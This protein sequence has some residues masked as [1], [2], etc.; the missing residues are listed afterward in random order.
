MSDKLRILFASYHS[1]LD[2]SSGSTISL[3][4]LFQLLIAGG[5]DCQAFCGA[6][7]DYEEARTIPQ[8]LDKVGAP[9]ETRKGGAYGLDFV[10]YNTIV[11]G[12]PIAVYETPAEPPA[13]KLSEKQGKVHLALFEKVLEQFR[14]DVVLTYG[15]Q[16][17]AYPAM[18]LAHRYGAAVVFWLRNTAYNHAGFFAQCDGVLVPSGFSVEFYRRTIGL[19]TTAIPSPLDWTRVAC[20]HIDRRFLTFVNPTPVKGVY[21]FAALVR[22]LARRRPDIPMLVVESRGKVGW[23]GKTGLQP[24]ELSGIHGMHN[25]ADPRKFYGVTRALLAPS[26]WPET[27]G[28]VTAESLINGIPVLCSTRG[29]LPEVVGKG[30]FLFDIPDKYT[31]DTRE[32]PTTE[33]IEPWIRTIERLWDDQSLYVTACLRA[34]VEAEKWRPAHL[35]DRYQQFFRAV[36]ARRTGGTARFPSL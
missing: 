31:P 22:E 17:M 11:A 18:Q 6:Q 21:V 3:R 5:W 25:T 26:L 32:I 36:V 34:R 19:E 7:L 29:G 35:A 8:V 9:F 27:F 20:D 10:L 14:P 2:P 1:Y 33:E 24:A 13:R 28:R 23:L 16:W 4:D 15:G 12:V 30:G